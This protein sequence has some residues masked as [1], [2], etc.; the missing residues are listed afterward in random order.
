VPPGAQQAHPWPSVAGPGGPVDPLISPDYAGWWERSINLVK[1]F[2]QPLV[3]LQAIGA[4]AGLIVLIPFGIYSI[5]IASKLPQTGQVNDAN[6]NDFMGSYFAFIGVALIGVVLAGLIS[7]LVELASLRLLASGVAGGPA[8]VGT[9]LRGA[10]PR[11]LPVIGWGILGGLL[12]LVGLCLCIIPGLYVGAVL[13][14]LPAVVLFERGGAIGRCFK[15]FNGN[16]GASLARV[17]TIWGIGLVAALVGIT[18][19]AIFSGV[20]GGTATNPSVAAEVAGSVVQV[21]LT[22]AL[23]VLL[24]PLTLTTYADMRARVEPLSTA[25]LASELNQ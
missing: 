12:V 16:F 7:I 24:A 14:V 2:W 21:I 18:I 23:G 13:V 15:L 9:A 6:I 5:G 20:F 4:V 22:G 10:L 25:V 8:D 3:I 1:R 19:S 11:V 17:A